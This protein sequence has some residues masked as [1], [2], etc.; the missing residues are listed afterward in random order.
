MRSQENLDDTYA[1]KKKPRSTLRWEIVYFMTSS[2]IGVFSISIKDFFIGVG[3]GGWTTT[4]CCHPIPLFFGQP[5]AW[6][7]HN[8]IIVLN[9]WLP[10]DEFI[11][12]D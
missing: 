4:K 6:P 12:K 1:P 7:N 5:M 9:P 3:W 10:H 8:V 2:Y 11:K